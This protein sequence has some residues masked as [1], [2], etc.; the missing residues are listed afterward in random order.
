MFDR[1]MNLQESRG[2]GRPRPVSQK[3]VVYT[4]NKKTALKPL[5][6][7]L[8]RAVDTIGDLE[9]AM[10]LSTYS[11]TVECT[12]ESI[13]YHLDQRN[14]DRLI[15]KRNPATLEMLRDIVH[16]K[17][18][19]HFSRLHE[20]S[21]P[22]YRFFLY[23]LD[24][25]EKESRDAPRTSRSKPQQTTEVNVDNLHKGPL[26]N[27]Y[28]PGSVFFLI[29]KRAKEMKLRQRGR[30]VAAVGNRGR[31]FQF[32][33]VLHGRQRGFSPP[34]LD[35]ALHETESESML[36]LVQSGS[37]LLHGV[38]ENDFIEGIQEFL[39]QLFIV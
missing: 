33:G 19:L 31:D 29:R 2:G 32:G 39:F 3:R 8:A 21:I 9:M 5:E 13:V 4:E 15:E 17:L 6:L 30:G 27:M 35:S 16:T 1:E 37:R 7:C 24:E 22:L 11:Q 34:P 38:D 18:T 14:Y 25:K 12:E 20:N 10:G 36:N 23:T 26:V 28:G